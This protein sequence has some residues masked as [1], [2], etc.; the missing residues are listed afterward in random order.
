MIPLA[1]TLEESSPAIGL[2][3]LQSDETIENEFRTIFS[4][5]IPLYHSRIPSAPEVT[6]KTLVRMEKYLA[7]TSAL[8]PLGAR[9][10]A[11]GYACTSG[12][13]MIG[14]DNIAASIQQV[15]PHTPVSD[16]LEAT[17]VACHSLQVRRLGLITPYIESVSQGIREHF[18]NAGLEIEALGSFGTKE[19]KVVAK[20]SE[21]S[22]LKAILEM[23]N[24]EA[25]DAVFVS[26]TN[27][28][29]LPILSEAEEK[30]GKPVLSSNQALAWRL[31][32]LAG[33]T[34]HLSGFGE[35]CHI[36]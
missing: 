20:I 8:F 2:I 24:K 9:F 14:S 15:H 7:Q 36:H 35:L 19:E 29:T 6:P 1:F 33:Y 5:S 27:L 13:R 12:A 18:E 31:L 4:A 26:C 16:P 21:A 11:I 32:R 22:V 30:I 23:G 17:L 28:R 3:V 10:G 25:I 34:S